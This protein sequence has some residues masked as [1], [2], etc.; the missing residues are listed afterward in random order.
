METYTPLSLWSSACLCMCV[1]GGKGAGGAAG[2]GGSLAE[3]VGEH[4][5]HAQAVL[6]EVSP[7]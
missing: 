6:V 5:H 4:C 1:V 2:Q 3:Y 7:F